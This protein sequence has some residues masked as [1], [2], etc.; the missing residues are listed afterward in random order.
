MGT[1]LSDD[2]L[3]DC[4]LVQISAVDCRRL[5]VQEDEMTSP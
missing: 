1:A 4:T 2:A 3:I 5:L